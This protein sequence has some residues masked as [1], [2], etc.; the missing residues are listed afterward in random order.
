MLQA[1]CLCPYCMIHERCT[2]VI[3]WVCVEISVYFSCLLKQWFNLTTMLLNRSQYFFLFFFMG[4]S[5][6]L[7]P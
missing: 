3:T 1:E 7:I 6:L 5:S 2:A 4:C